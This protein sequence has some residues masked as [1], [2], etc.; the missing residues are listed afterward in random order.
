MKNTCKVYRTLYGYVNSSCYGRYK[1]Y[2]KGMIDQING[3]RVAK[4][5]FIVPN[6]HAEQVLSYLNENDATVKSWEVIPKADE[7]ASLEK[8]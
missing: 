2:V 5:L 3:I 7:L 8:S 1:T 6:E 4:S